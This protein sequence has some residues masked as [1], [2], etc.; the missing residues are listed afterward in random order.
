MHSELVGRREVAITIH[1]GQHTLVRVT[2]VSF[3]ALAKLALVALG[4]GCLV[5]SALARVI[6][7]LAEPL[8]AASA[9]AFEAVT[10]DHE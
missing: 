4:C 6:G 1:E 2:H 9:A 7:H 10:G 5:A 3:A 8:G